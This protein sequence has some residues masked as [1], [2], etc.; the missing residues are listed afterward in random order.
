MSGRA[1]L[2]IERGIICGYQKTGKGKKSKMIYGL[3]KII[4]PLYK[5]TSL[6]ENEQSDIF[7]MLIT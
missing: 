1:A 2:Q 3:P 6:Q 5:Q 7:Y 4:C